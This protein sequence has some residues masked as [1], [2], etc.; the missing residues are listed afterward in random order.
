MCAM[1]IIA[2]RCGTD[3]YPEQTIAAARHSLALGVDYVEVDIRFTRDDKPVVIHDPTPESLY[4]VSTPVCELTETQFLALRRCSDPSVC[5]HS[6]PQFLECGIDKMLFHCKEGGQKLCRIVD[7]CKD[8]GILDKVVFGPQDSEDVRILKSYEDRVQ[9]LAFMRLPD[10]AAVMADAGAD[11]IRLWDPWVTQERIDQV[12]S[13]GR[14]LWIM[15][16][17][18]TVG[19]IDDLPRAYADYA[20]WGAD[21]ILVNRVEPAMAWYKKTK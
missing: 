8:Y 2:H 16:K 6:F 9:V 7:L 11:I 4:G 14:K 17:R 20:A 5:G 19:E 12:H 15:S 21:G 10:D 1:Q 3:R 18:P 13:L